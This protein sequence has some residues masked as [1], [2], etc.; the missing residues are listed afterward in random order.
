MSHMRT[1]SRNS[2]F[3][4]ELILALCFLALVCAGCIRLFAAA[5][6]DRTE[7]QRLNYIREN[8][9]RAGELLEGWNADPDQLALLF[10]EASMEDGSL[11]VSFDRKWT[12]TGP[13]NAFYFMRLTPQ[14]TETVKGGLLSFTDT[15]GKDLYSC[16]IRYPLLRSEEKGG[17]EA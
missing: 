14:V 9:I 7:A 1:H 8:T 16:E 15:E 3:L 4:A 10:P 6:L 12:V 2:L 11:V 13:E 5:Y 17:P